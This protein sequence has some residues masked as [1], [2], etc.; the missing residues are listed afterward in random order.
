MCMETSLG[1]RGK[2]INKNKNGSETGAV[3]RHCIG[4]PS[5]ELY[6]GE[7]SFAC[8]TITVQL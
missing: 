6:P 4:Y 2:K 3:Q 8:E 1:G 5:L 7:I